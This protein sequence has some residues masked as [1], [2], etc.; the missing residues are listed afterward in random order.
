M[1]D[2]VAG[3]WGFALVWGYRG[4]V[5][6]WAFTMALPNA[7]ITYGVA[8]MIEDDIDDQSQSTTVAAWSIL[9]TFTAVMWFIL[10]FRSDVAYDRWW[11]GG[12]LLQQTRGEWFNA[13]SSLLAFSAVDE[14]LMTKVEEFHHLLARFFSMLFCCALQQVSPG[15]NRPFEILSTYGIDPLSLNFLNGTDDK[16][17]VLLQWIQRS[18]VL[19]MHTG[20]LPIAPPVLS[21]AFQE[22]SRGIVNLQNA[23][24]IADF[25]FPFPYAQTSMVLLLLH[26][27]VV[28]VLC[29]ML[30]EKTK[31]AVVSFLV[32]FFLW[33]LNFI[34]L[35]LESPFGSE[36]NDLP[37][38]QMQRDW[39]NSLG[40]LLAR[41]VQRPPNFAFEPDVHR[42]LG[43]EQSDG[44]ASKTAR[45]TLMDRV[46]AA[47]MGHA[48]S[49][50]SLPDDVGDTDS[51]GFCKSQQGESQVASPVASPFESAVARPED[52]RGD[53][54]IVENEPIALI[55]ESPI[56]STQPY[57]GLEN[58]ESFQANG[59]D[60]GAIRLKLTSDGTGGTPPTDADEVQIETL[61]ETMDQNQTQTQ[62]CTQL[63]LLSLPNSDCGRSNLNSR[64]PQLPK[65]PNEPP[66]PTTEARPKSNSASAAANSGFRGR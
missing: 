19:H 63:L 17:E 31:A 2:Y 56:K 53:D 62:T 66:H 16:V 21:R 20:V 51:D 25:P 28:P 52:S 42:N 11:E 59:I 58:G 30:L 50:E 14:R 41:R 40:T 54:I 15:R 43:I 36:A 47:D 3:K 27:S 60:E 37:M 34:A 13:Y 10:G 33:C 61:L 12:T 57:S 6:P 46:S 45:V 22:M 39:N 18:I 5:F 1:R 55:P 26:W 24:K 7:L 65:T 8:M 49:E 29:A 23:R 38:E 4:S 44:S 32:V 64:E 9:G 35:Q 48:T